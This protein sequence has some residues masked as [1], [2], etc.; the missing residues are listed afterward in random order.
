MSVGNQAC[1]LLIVLLCV[2]FSTSA[3]YGGDEERCPPKAT[4]QFPVRSDCRKFLNCYKGRGIVQSCAPGTLFNPESMECDFPSKVNCLDSDLNKPYIGNYR[5]RIDDS[6]KSDQFA[7]PSYELQPGSYQV[8]TQRFDTSAPI[9][10]PDQN[11]QPPPS[12]GLGYPHVPKYRPQ[13]GTARQVQPYIVNQPN[14]QQPNNPPPPGQFG[15]FRPNQPDPLYS[16]YPQ[17]NQEYPIPGAPL[18]LENQ[19]QRN[20]KSSRTGSGNSVIA[21]GVVQPEASYWKPIVVPNVDETKTQTKK[22]YGLNPEKTKGRAFPKDQNQK[23]TKGNQEAAPNTPPKCPAGESGLFPHPTDCKKFLSC[24]HGRTFV[25]D[26]GPGTAFNPAS[27][28]CDWPK[29][30][31]CPNYEEDGD[32]SADN[33]QGEYNRPG[34]YTENEQDPLIPQSS[35]VQP[36]QTQLPSLFTPYQPNNAPSS[37][38]PPNNQ[39]NPQQPNQADNFPNQSRPPYPNSQ[40]YYPH[41]PIDTHPSNDN[42]PQ[43]SRN[44]AQS[45]YRPSSPFELNNSPTQPANIPNQGRAPYPN[46]HQPPP[47]PQQPNVNYPSNAHNFQPIKNPAQSTNKPSSPFDQTAPS[48]N[49]SSHSSPYA[50]NQPSSNTYSPHQN[51]NK[52]NSYTQPYQPNKS[53]PPR[54]SYQPDEFGSTESPDSQVEIDDLYIPSEV[55]P[56]TI[57]T[58]PEWA[59]PLDI[60]VRINFPQEATDKTPKPTVKPIKGTVNSRS[61]QNSPPEQS[62]KPTNTSKPKSNITPVLPSM[63]S[64]SSQVA[65]LRGGPKPSEGFLELKM[66]N[67]KWGITCDEPNSWNINEAHIVCKQLGYE[68]GAELTWQGRPTDASTSALKEIAVN[69]VKCSGK[70]ASVLDCKIRKEKSCDPERDGVW[71]RCQNNYASLCRPGEITYNNRCYKLVVPQ[72]NSTDASNEGFSQGE[73]LAHCSSIG[74]KLLNILSQNENDFLSEWLVGQNKADNIMTSGV[75]VSIM[76][77]SLWIWEGSEDSFVYHNWWP[78]WEGGRSVAPK[79]QAGRGQCVIAQRHFPCPSSSSAPDQ[80]KPH[81]PPRL[82]DAEYYFWSTADCG[83]MSTKHPYVCKRPVDDIGCVKDTGRDYA[84][85]ANV[86]TNGEACLSWNTPSVFSALK[87]RISEKTHQTLLRDHNFCRNPDG[88]DSS[89]WCFVKAPTGVRKEFCDI[90]KCEDSKTVGKDSIQDFTPTSSEQCSPDGY[91]CRPGDCIPLTWICDGQPDCRI[92]ENE[93]NC[94]TVLEKFTYY[95]SARLYGYDVEAWDDVSPEAC[96]FRC[97]KTTSFECRSFSYSSKDRSCY[98]SDNNVGISGALQ[99][100]SRE[101]EWDYYEMNARSLNCESLFI[102]NNG[103]CIGKDDVCDG[104]ADC[105]DFSDENQC[106][107]RDVGFEIRLA[108]GKSRNEGRIEVKALGEWGVVCDD[109]FNLMAATVACKEL[110]FPLGAAE[111]KT[112]SFFQPANVTSQK[113]PLYLMD[114]VRCAGN[115]SSISKCSFNGWGTHDCGPEEVAGVVCKT[116]STSCPS[117]Q[118]QCEK[119]KECIPIKF[120]CDGEVDC[121]DKSDESPLKCKAPVSLRVVGPATGK[122]GVTEGRLEIKRFGVWGTICDDDFSETEALVACRTLGFYGPAKFR[123]EAAFGAGTGPIWLDEVHCGGNE[124]SIEKCVHGIWGQSNCQHDE[125]VSIVCTPG[126]PPTSAP[127]S[128]LHNRILFPD[129]SA[130]LV[131]SASNTLQL[132]PKECAVADKNSNGSDAQKY[133]KIAVN[134]DVIRG[135]YPWQASLRVRAGTQTIHWCGAIVISS[136]HILTAGHCLEDY[137]KGAYYVRVGDHDTEIK[138]DGEQDLEV[139]EIYLHENFNAGKKL[140]NDIALVKVKNPLKFNKYVQPICLPNSSL[141]Y[142]PGLNCTI[143]GWGSVG[144]PGSGYVRKLKATWVPILSNSQCSSDAVYGKAA[145][146]EGMFCAGYLEGGPDSCKGDSGGPMACFVNDQY[147]L[148]GITSWGL[149]CGLANKPGVYSNV[150]LYRPWIDKKIR[151]SLRNHKELRVGKS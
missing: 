85:N 141:K 76:G 114:D 30:V 50:P 95:P 5:Q 41:Q 140:N 149:G 67:G 36:S 31:D 15:P 130:N 27:S 112:N 144:N 142:N 84:G 6:S 100:N 82:C 61:L 28:I 87:Y 90:P 12:N 118:W 131:D 51:S 10:Y 110:G 137:S 103:K 124:T 66:D 136:L 113:P 96:A 122:S 32:T 62:L 81:T 1:V 93:G 45:N 25:M 125:D 139:D 17:G 2:T 3:I 35:N 109:S 29:N 116:A 151:S 11:L 97:L 43:P 64:V 26:C 49:P 146:S 129:D 13:Q 8:P 38:R 72:E 108:G 53:T 92:T 147:T 54:P 102:C 111:V 143:S 132:F 79:T 60:D 126:V 55:P 145:L 18:P 59:E 23:A 52:P 57:V 80:K 9:F 150:A 4:G 37:F 14:Y 119:T 24:A 56:Q 75:G 16:N 58:R 39:R 91:E 48:K 123:K 44:P 135:T 47:Y 74:G 121:D 89:P 104:H 120:L 77:R 46:S 83:E 34:Q 71:I 78:G 63:K 98:L 42:H 19:N 88:L 101:Q 128:R 148:F 65:R 133:A 40:N 117:D 7:R 107:N 73:A 70:E 115:E 127:E 94:S 86:T 106:P 33:E 21:P 138:E 105:S 20:P 99:V 134:N 69:S 22:P 68:R